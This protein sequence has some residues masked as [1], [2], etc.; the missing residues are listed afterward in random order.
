M[1][2]KKYLS[3]NITNMPRLQTKYRK[4]GCQNGYGRKKKLHPWA[5]RGRGKQKG[6]LL[7]TGLAALG[8]LIYAGISAA[9]VPVATGILTS[10]AGYGTTRAIQAIEARQKGRGRKLRRRR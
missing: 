10:A 8:S 1:N 4:G 2:K 7:F 9:A 5:R 6:G 3:Q